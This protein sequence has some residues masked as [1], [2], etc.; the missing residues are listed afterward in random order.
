MDLLDHLNGVH[1]VLILQH[2]ITSIEDHIQVITHSIHL[3]DMGVIINK[4]LQGAT[5][6]VVGNKGLACRVHPHI[7]VVM[8]TMADKEA[9]CLMPQHLPNILLQ[10]LH[11]VMALPMLLLWVHH[12]PRQITIMDNHRGQIMDIQLL[13]LRQHLTSRAMAMD[14]MNQNM[15]I[16]LQHSIPMEDMEVLSQCTHRLNRV[17]LHSSM[18][19][20]SHTDRDHIPNPMPLLEPLNQGKYLTKVLLLLNHM[21]Q[22]QL[23]NNLTHINPVGRCSNHIL[24]MVLYLLLM[25]I[26]SH[27]LHLVLF[28]HSKE[29]SQVMVSLVHSRHKGMRKWVLLGVM[30][31]TQLHNKVTQS[32]QLLTMQLTVTKDHKILLTVVPLLQP[33]VHHQAVSQVML[34]QL[35]LNKVTTSLSH[36]REVMEAHQQPLRLLMAKLCHLSLV[37]LS[38]TQLKCMARLVENF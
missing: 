5:T 12:H 34:N 9:T 6:V 16:M 21:A 3:Q 31:H 35:Q 32:R 38:M 25:L 23:L 37:T 26:I 22:M 7:L 8:I 28:I 17:M 36:N 4:P 33:I 11:M 10:F 1:G 19:S 30:A 15:K 2:M 20:H 27:H 14:M 18:V 24:H 13:I 29:G